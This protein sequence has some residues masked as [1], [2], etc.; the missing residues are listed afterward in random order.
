M[1]FGKKKKRSPVP[2]EE[3]RGRWRLE[4]LA[5]R[6]VL[7]NHLQSKLDVAADPFDCV[8]NLAGRDPVNRAA[9]YRDPEVG[10]IQNIEELRPKLQSAAFTEE[11]QGSI[12]S[13]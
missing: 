5:G 4:I 11:G 7:K 10:V 1:A 6:A 9:S 12:F 3:A 13:H 2:L 8:V